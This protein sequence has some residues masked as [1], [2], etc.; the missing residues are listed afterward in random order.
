MVK[1]S[2]RSLIHTWE[3]FQLL[4]TKKIQSF[5]LIILSEEKKL[6]GGNDCL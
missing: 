3:S 6:G 5:I 2:V 1:V 4:G